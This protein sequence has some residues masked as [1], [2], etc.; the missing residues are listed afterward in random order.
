MVYNYPRVGPPMDRAMWMSQQAG[1]SPA[2][3]GLLETFYASDISQDAEKRVFKG[4][5]RNEMFC[6]DYISSDFSHEALARAGK[7]IY[8][9]AEV[10]RLYGHSVVVVPTT[11]YHRLT[12]KPH[13]WIDTGTFHEAVVKTDL[14][15]VEGPCPDQYTEKDT[16]DALQTSFA[17]R[18]LGKNKPTIFLDT[19]FTELP[20]VKQSRSTCE[21]IDAQEKEN[22]S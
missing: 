11:N 12:W 1:F 4:I 16:W 17:E 19:R 10:C 20:I 2:L 8:T 18:V 6:F 14:V 5:L 7:S 22:D 3:S 15:I 21:Y 13:P 9:V